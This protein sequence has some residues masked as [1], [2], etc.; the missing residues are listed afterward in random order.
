MTTA[1]CQTHAQG[2]TQAFYHPVQQQTT[3]GDLFSPALKR[4]SLWLGQM[5]FGAGGDAQDRRCLS[6]P[7]TRCHWWACDMWWHPGLPTTAKGDRGSFTATSGYF[8]P[9][10][11]LPKS[12][13]T[14]QNCPGLQAIKSLYGESRQFLDMGKRDFKGG[15]R[16]CL[17]SSPK[18]T[19]AF[20]PKLGWTLELEAIIG[21]KI[22][23]CYAKA[24]GKELQTGGQTD[25]FSIYC[26][27]NNTVCAFHPRTRKGFIILPNK[28][29]EH[30]RK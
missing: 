5:L 13:Q 30:L 21:A 18:E 26:S 10:P 17:N 25:H 22:N 11:K 8:S 28:G 9:M 2:K 15:S 6:R 4:L 20:Q 27:S 23:S 12:G 19:C 29:S 7:W 24:V 3:L 14:N 1:T 16:L